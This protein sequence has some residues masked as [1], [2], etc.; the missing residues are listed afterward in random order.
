MGIEFESIL[1][2]YGR[3]VKIEKKANINLKEYLTEGTHITFIHGNM[4]KEMRAGVIS[5]EGRAVRIVNYDTNI[6]RNIDATY[7]KSIIKKEK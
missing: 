4:P 7:I 2:Q 6:V 3:A 5:V 1:K